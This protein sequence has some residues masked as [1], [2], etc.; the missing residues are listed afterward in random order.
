MQG[1][2]TTREQGSVTSLSDR[3]PS[4]RRV[5]PPP[6][7]QRTGGRMW[8][9]GHELGGPADRFKHLATPPG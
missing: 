2:H 8:I 7:G 1:L 4:L 6:R 9:N 3:R 5:E